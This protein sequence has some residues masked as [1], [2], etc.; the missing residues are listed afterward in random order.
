MG[1]RVS[2]RVVVGMRVGMVVGMGMGVAVRLRGVDVRLKRVGVVVL[3]LRRRVRTVLLACLIVSVEK[4]AVRGSLPDVAIGTGEGFVGRGRRELRTG[5][6]V[7]VT[8]M[9]SCRIAAGG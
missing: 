6:G 8:M 5:E 1:V 2:T 4:A 9:V 3:M 7:A